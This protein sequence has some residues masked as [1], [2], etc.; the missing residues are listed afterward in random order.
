VANPLSVLSELEEGTLTREHVE[1]LKMVYPAMYEEL[2]VRVLQEVEKQPDLAYSKRLQLGVLL[3]IPTDSSLLGSSIMALQ[4]RYA[5]QDQGPGRPTE[6]R[7]AV[8]VSRARAV[9]KSTRMQTE[10]ERIS[11]KE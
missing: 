6:P 2:Q 3:D 11:N 8:P 5:P 1:A 9:E 7:G 4:A 10:A